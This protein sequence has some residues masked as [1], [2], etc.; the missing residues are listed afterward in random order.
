VPLKLL[1]SVNGES[2]WG[3]GRLYYVQYAKQAQKSRKAPCV[4]GWVS[5][6][7]SCTNGAMHAADVATDYFAGDFGNS[8]V[9]FVEPPA[10]RV[11]IAELPPDTLT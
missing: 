8:E 11:D 10:E 4:V 9:L 7:V 6:P 1:Q 5:L 3:D 2:I